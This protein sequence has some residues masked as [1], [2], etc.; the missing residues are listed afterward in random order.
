MHPDAWSRM[1]GGTAVDKGK[2]IV[3]QFVTLDGVVEDPGGRAFRF[4]P[5]RVAGDDL[6]W[7]RSSVVA[8]QDC[9]TH[10]L[11]RRE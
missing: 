3:S 7:V 8:R 10:F 11:D 5:K 9:L 2:V 6:N 1:N 4:G